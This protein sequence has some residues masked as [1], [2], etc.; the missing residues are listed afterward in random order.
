[1]SPAASPAYVADSK[2]TFGGAELRAWAKPLP[3][4]GHTLWSWSK[5]REPWYPTRMSRPSASVFLASSL[6]GFIARVDGAIDWLAVVERPNEDYGIKAFY[7]SVDTIVMG[8]KTYD[9]GL[10]FEPWPYAKMRCVVVTSDT[11]RT[12]RH[13]EEFYSGEL[14]PLFERLGAEGAKHIYVDGGIVIAQALRA[15]LVDD[16][17][18]SVIPIVLGEGTPLAPKLGADVGLELVEHRAFESGLV[19]LKYR[20]KR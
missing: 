2:G 3:A 6:D 10:G 5:A 20:V 12:P 17:T 18:V 15:G 7:D 14:S 19:Q 1:M 8:R 9:V 13:G 11:K 4:N 16:I